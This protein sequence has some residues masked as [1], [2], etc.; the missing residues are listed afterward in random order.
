MHDT[1]KQI[2]ISKTMDPT[3]EHPTDQ[4]TRDVS[5]PEEQQ[6][7]PV[8]VTPPTTT[9]FTPPSPV[10]E[11]AHTTPTP[12]PTLPPA[13]KP[14]EFGSDIAHSKR[15]GSS[16]IISA[17]IILLVAG[18]LYA[19][20]R[21]GQTTK[22]PTAAVHKDV[23]LVRVGESDPLPTTFYPNVDDS[24]I[25]GDVSGQ[26][27]EGLTGFEDKTTIVPRLAVSWTNPNTSTWVFKLRPNVKFHSG[28]T[29]TATDVKA[30]LDDIQN[31][32]Y[33]ADFG[34]TIASV[35]VVDPLTVEIKT[36]GPDPLIPNELTQLWIY[37]TTSK[38]PNNPINGTGAYNLKS[39]DAKTGSIDMVA[40]DQYWGGRPHVREV[41]FNELQGAAG[42]LAAIKAKSDDIISSQTDS[43]TTAAE[44]L[45]FNYL[46]I[47]QPSVAQLMMN[48]Q[49]VG[50]PL[51]KLAVR[52]ALMQ[53]LSPTALL[54]SRDITGVPA[55]QIVPETIPGYD[56]SIVRPA[57]NTTAAK[58]ALA[59]AGYPNGFTITLTYYISAQDLAD[60]VQKEF[61]VVGVKI[62]EDPESDLSVLGS[63]AL[64]GGTDM[65]YNAV[66]TSLVDG[67]D[68]FAGFVQSKNFDDPQVDALFTQAGQTLDS[69]KRLAI[70]QQISRLL[71][72]DRADLP[73]YST[74]DNNWVVTPSLVLNQNSYYGSLS[75]RFVEAYGK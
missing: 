39:I 50:S 51:A 54:A 30:S 33:G 3:N 17:I 72:Q 47:L 62:V 26:A 55:S 52:N 70:L 57:F 2:N 63:K 73:L 23:A 11:P 35:S 29:M 24:S 7:V 9:E 15:R 28:R 8:S 75:V 44:K 1:G 5:Q 56:P 21:Y 68:V 48:S 36:N 66:N 14:A 22:A 13:D 45:G 60:E 18:G 53:A 31:F 71:V 6:S 69:T 64:G 10:S 58:A 19:V 65:Y 74:P 34:T 12:L 42:A 41:Q 49:K 61:A 46:D 25:N 40:F 67:T 4:E 37:D 20:Y 16:W 32:P 43:N 27:F 38:T 59:A